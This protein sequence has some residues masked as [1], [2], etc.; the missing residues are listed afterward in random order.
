MPMHDTPHGPWARAACARK[1]VRARAQAPAKP[2]Y[3]AM[4]SR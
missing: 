1:D 4:R 3:E 2:M